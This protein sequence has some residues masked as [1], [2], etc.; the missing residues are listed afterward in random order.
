MIYYA[1][2]DL[3][4]LFC[5]R[6]VTIFVLHFSV[7][8]IKKKKQGLTFKESCLVGFSGMI[9]G[10]IA[11]A[12]IAKLTST[13]S[14]S[15]NPEDPEKAK[16][17]ICIAQLVIVATMFIFV[18][19]NPILFEKLLGKD[20]EADDEEM[21]KSTVIEPTQTLLLKK[22][23][24]LINN[25]DT[26]FSVVFKRLDDFVLKPCLIR[27][28]EQ[29]VVNILLMKLK[30][31]GEKKKEAIGGSKVSLLKQ[32]YDRFSFRMTMRGGDKLNSLIAPIKEESD[33]E[34][35]AEERD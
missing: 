7:S 30:I 13:Q 31:K 11:Y 18:P 33:D 21:Q 3:V 20:G 32:A 14:Q 26:K 15:G 10:S 35:K 34:V 8:F 9:R 1:I 2:I 12:M 6:F 28:Y 4:V 24:D 5:L 25:K 22:R 27:D 19:L 29:R 16:E 23:E 17:L